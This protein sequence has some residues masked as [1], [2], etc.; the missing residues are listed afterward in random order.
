M[1]PTDNEVA[2]FRTQSL[3][4]MCVRQAGECLL[5]A[6]VAQVLGDHLDSELVLALWSKITSS[7][8]LVSVIIT[9]V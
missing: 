2:V 3:R 1:A 8:T 7:I 4:K 5:P 9:F 6:E